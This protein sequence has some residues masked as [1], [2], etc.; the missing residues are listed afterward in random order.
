MAPT[1]VKEKKRASYIRMEDGT[2]EDYQLVMSSVKV[3]SARLPDRLLQFMEN[4][5]DSYEGEQID[6]YQHCLQTATRAFRDQADD[7][8]VV[9]ALLHDIGDILSSDNH[10]EYA[11]SIIRP[12]VRNETYWMIKHHAIFQGYF[13]YHHIGRDRDE[14]EKYR[15]HPCFEITADFCGKWDQVAFD[16]TYDTMPKSAFEPI[17]RRVFA[18]EPWSLHSP[19]L[20]Y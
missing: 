19:D 5:H 17:L 13:Y 1:D 11:A 4:L 3:F 14:R 6:R 20:G 10:A 7:E 8:T 12:F 9:A 15:G 2:A 18:R 16:P